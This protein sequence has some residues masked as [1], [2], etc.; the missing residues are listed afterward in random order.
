M[1]MPDLI[2]NDKPRRI[3]WRCLQ[4]EPVGS[5]D[6]GPCPCC[7]K[8]SRTVWGFV[9]SPCAI[10]ATYFV[11]WTLNG[12]QH[13]ANFDLAV[14]KWEEDTGPEDRQAISLE[15][16]IIEGRG[17]FKVINAD[18]R[19]VADCAWAKVAL[20]R[21]QVVGLPL[22]ADVFAMVDAIFATDER[23]QELRSW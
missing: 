8:T 16:R 18:T 19:P 21:D 4:I 12:R 11:H 3:D 1:T 17:S 13:G 5:R 15:Y 7:G 2:A 10:L 14:G 22:A 9:H 23:I 6:F 20:R